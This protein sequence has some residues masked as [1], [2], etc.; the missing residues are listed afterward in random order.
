MNKVLLVGIG[1]ALVVII[2]LP[3]L[4][5]KVDELPSEVTEDGNGFMTPHYAQRLRL[6]EVPQETLRSCLAERTYEEVVQRLGVPG[7]QLQQKD[8]LPPI[9]FEH[10]RNI[11]REDIVHPEK[12]VYAW[13]STYGE[14][15]TITFRN[16]EN[17]HVYY[18][19]GAGP[20]Q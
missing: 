17:V 19:Q 10:L 13:V 9:P 14:V 15:M 4:V 11:W 7:V 5:G 8:D 2:A 16:G 18:G 6:R 3:L 12:E 20:D 1:L